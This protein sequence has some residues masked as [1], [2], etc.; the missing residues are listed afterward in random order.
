MR[1][2]EHYVLPDVLAPGLRVVFCGTAASNVS[3]R[4][5]APYAGPGNRFWETLYRVGLLPQRLQPVDFRQVLKY[6]IGLTDLVKHSSGVDHELQREDFQVAA[7]LEKM[8]T[9]RPGCIAWTSK[10]AASL[11]LGRSTRA[12]HYGLQQERIAGA[13]LYVLPSP[14]GAAR[15]YWDEAVWRGLAAF[16]QQPPQDERDG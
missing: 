11:C 3:A 6:G 7:F 1:N 10:K 12:I 9:Y 2:Q 4:V 5:G 13:A 16:L 14:S 15:A 8:H